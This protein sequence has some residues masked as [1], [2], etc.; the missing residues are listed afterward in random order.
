LKDAITR[1][2]PD[3]LAR[4]TGWFEEY[5]AQAW[6]EQIKCDATAGRFDGLIQRAYEQ[7]EAGT[8]RPDRFF[9]EGQLERLSALMDRWRRACATGDALPTEE[10]AELEVLVH[11]EWRAAGDRVEALI[12][13]KPNSSNA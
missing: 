7:L 12:S 13:G 9:G 8:C 10:Q 5:Q 6:D 4:F 1:L 11:S 3:D 2:T